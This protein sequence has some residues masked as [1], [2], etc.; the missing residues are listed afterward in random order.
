M[1]KRELKG[2]LVSL[3]GQMTMVLP[4]HISPLQIERVVMTEVSKNPAILRC[5][6]TSILQSVME[7]C[8][9]G[10]IPNS[11]Q[12]LAYLIPYGPKCQLIPGYKGLM[13]LAMQS[14][15]FSKI[16]SRAVHANDPH[17]LI[18]EGTENPR[19]EHTPMYGE[20]RGELIGCY[21]AARIKEDGSSYFE[22]M[23][24]DEID[25]IKT[26]SK[27]GSSG[28]WKTDYDEMA[29]KTVLRRLVKSLPSDSEKLDL[30]SAK[31]ESGGSGFSYSLD[32]GEWDYVDG[33][34]G[35]TASDD[36]TKRFAPKNVEAKPKKKKASQPPP[37]I[38]DSGEGASSLTPKEE[39]IKQLQQCAVD[40][41]PAG[42]KKLYAKEEE[43]WGK[44][45]S[46][47]DRAEVDEMCLNLIEEGFDT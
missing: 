25:K 45:M 6:Q 31:A 8:S 29:R 4:P 7:A 23:S 24:R 33:E 10:L 30:A 44:I 39:A 18:V 1:D 28:P 42:V 43:N 12:G 46:P 17:F 47:D 32:K 11:V 37:L 20:D 15:H 13:K 22:F 3:H 27:S 40:N 26:R 19:I 16:W 41:G 14:G 5:T 21:A 9:L 2:N 34:D 35:D 36:L 38:V